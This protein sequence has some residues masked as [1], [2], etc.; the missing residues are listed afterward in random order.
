[1]LTIRGEGNM[2]FDLYDLSGKRVLSKTVRQQETLDISGFS[3]GI[4]FYKLS[5]DKQVALKTGK[6]VIQ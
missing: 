1:M 6:L 5:T 3:G 2:L 4:Y